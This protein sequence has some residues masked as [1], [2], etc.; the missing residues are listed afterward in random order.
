MKSVRTRARWALSYNLGHDRYRRPEIDPNCIAVD[1]KA[2][3]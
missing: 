2:L 3:H 1:K